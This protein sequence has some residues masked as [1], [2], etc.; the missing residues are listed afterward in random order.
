MSPSSKQLINSSQ[1]G[2]TACMSEIIGVKLKDNTL[3][4]LRMYYDTQSQ[5][6]LC[7]K[8]AIKLMT[9]SRVSTCKIQFETVTG[10]DCQKRKICKLKI[11]DDHVIDAILV[12]NLRIGSLFMEKPKEWYKYQNE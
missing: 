1:I 6:T 12:N 9:N 3:V 8:E 10:K 4:N 7:N 5:H 11:S 2:K